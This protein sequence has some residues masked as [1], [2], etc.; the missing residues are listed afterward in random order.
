[1]IKLKEIRE[2]VILFDGVCHLCTAGIQFII[3]KD[4]K[5]KFRF[6]S[7][8]GKFGQQ[9]LQQLHLP[10]T[11]LDSF[12]LLENGK[13]YT[14]SMAALKIAKR[15]SGLWP[16]LYVL[17]IIPS[18]IRNT[19]YRIIASNRYRWFGKRNECWIPS[20]QINSRFLN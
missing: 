5:N 10:A 15:L 20:A 11:N 3:K 6:A 12:I 14:Q 8:Q 9:L 18:F 17:I 13:I 7:L 4:K 1:M 16:F 2:P 19:I